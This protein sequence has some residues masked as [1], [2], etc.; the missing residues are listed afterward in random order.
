MRNCC[1]L[2]RHFSV[3]YYPLSLLPQLK[4]WFTFIIVWKK[5]NNFYRWKMSLLPVDMITLFFQNWETNIFWFVSIKITERNFWS[6]KLDEKWAFKTIL[7]FMLFKGGKK[8]WS[9]ISQNRKGNDSSHCS[10]KIKKNYQC[11]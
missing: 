1:A 6:K 2:K 11:N 10:G 7:K 3:G 8:H 5:K 4:A 9:W